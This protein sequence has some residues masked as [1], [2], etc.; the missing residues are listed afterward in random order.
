ML[1]VPG[2]R[3]AAAAG[4][5]KNHEKTLIRRPEPVN[6]EEKGHPAGDTRVR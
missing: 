6:K 1:P 2:D 5:E 3:S 4:S